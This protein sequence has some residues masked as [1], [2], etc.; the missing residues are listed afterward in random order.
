M[1][2]REDY[3]YV[4]DI[5]P[6]EQ[7]LARDPSLI[8]KGFPRNE[9][10]VQAIGE[11]YF[12]LLELT[13]KPNVTVEVGERVY[14]GNGPRD[15]VDKIV[16][17]IGYDELT[18]EAKNVLPEIVAKIVKSQES[19]FVDFFNK[20]GPITLKMHTLELLRGIGKKTL[21]QILE[22]RKKKPFQ[23]FEDIRSRVGIDP[24]KLI[25][26]RILRELQGADQYRIFVG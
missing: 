5:I 15:K 23:S 4:L 8:R 14:I 25:V 9:Q 3:A 18:S 11:Q 2:K 12:T 26:D 1:V 22:E 17:R 6:P 16:R 7:M 21:W 19:R 24:E 20:A 13:L 10:Y